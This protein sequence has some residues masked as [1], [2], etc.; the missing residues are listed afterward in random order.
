LSKKTE[1]I[2]PKP[3]LLVDV[4]YTK[5]QPWVFNICIQICTTTVT[6]LAVGSQN[7][8]YVIVK[9]KERFDKG[10]VTYRKYRVNTGV[11]QNGIP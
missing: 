3:I 4:V 8:D 5:I 1:R 7:D 2:C 6:E 10:L 11:V 9:Q